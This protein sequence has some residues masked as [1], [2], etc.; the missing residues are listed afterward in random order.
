MRKLRYTLYYT[1]PIFINNHGKQ[2]WTDSWHPTNESI[3]CKTIGE[4][5]EYLSIMNSNENAYIVDNVTN[6]RINL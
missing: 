2:D 5:K 3:D 4:A 1:S 6:K